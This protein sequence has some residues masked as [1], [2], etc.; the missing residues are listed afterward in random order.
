MQRSAVAALQG[1]SRA[2]AALRELRAPEE[3]LERVLEV[4]GGGLSAFVRGLAAHCAA[5]PSRL[6]A[7]E[8]WVVGGSGSEG[9][10]AGGGSGDR[11]TLLP[12]RLARELT[13]AMQHYQ[14]LCHVVGG[15]GGAGPRVAADARGL[16]RRVRRLRALQPGAGGGAWRW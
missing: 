3:A 2:A 12:E 1:L 5:L 16:L 7:A 8:R 13:A 9:G 15:A 4:L 10:S 14:A 11:V 6:V